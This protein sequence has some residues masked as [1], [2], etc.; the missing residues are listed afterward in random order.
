VATC[1][2]IAKDIRNQYTIAYIPSD[3]R[4]DNPRRTINVTAAGH[5]DE[6]LVVRTRP[7][8]IASPA[9]PKTLERRTPRELALAAFLR[10][11]RG[12]WRGAH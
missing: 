11:T 6:K 2:Q 7:S 12:N 1:E 9:R 4:L 5:H 3:R 10:E 8:Y